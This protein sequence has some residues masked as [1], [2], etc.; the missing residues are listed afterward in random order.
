MEVDEV[1]GGLEEF[2]FPA[3]SVDPD[4]HSEGGRR[5]SI[6]LQNG[7]RDS[8]GLEDLG[9]AAGGGITIGVDEIVDEGSVQFRRWKEATLKLRHDV[10][11][12]FCLF[13][14]FCLARSHVC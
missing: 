8:V 7:A 12:Y 4:D 1:N 3:S 6:G 11:V 2:G 9:D 13:L 14:S 10:G 5:A